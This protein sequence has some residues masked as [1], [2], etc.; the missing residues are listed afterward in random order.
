M[1]DE[2]KL[3]QEGQVIIKKIEDSLRQLKIE[4]QKSLNDY[5]QLKDGDI[6]IFEKLESQYLKLLSELQ[7]SIEETTSL[8]DRAIAN[9]EKTKARKKIKAEFFL[10]GVIWTLDEVEVEEEKKKEIIEIAKK[11][12]FRV[13]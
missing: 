8:W 10:T 3:I 5:D 1:F 11:L 6:E 2:D 12:I 13:S 4:Y 7:K 9:V